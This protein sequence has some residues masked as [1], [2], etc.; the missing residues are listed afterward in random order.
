MPEFPEVTVVA[1][2]L[3]SLVK[4]KKIISITTITP[5]L[6]K[7]NGF[8][9]FQK[10][11]TDQKIEKVYNIGKFI[12]FEL[13]NDLKMISHLRMEGK[14]FF[15]KESEDNLRNKKHDL[16]WFYFSDD[17]VLIYNDTRRFGTLE[18]VKGDVKNAKAIAKLAN[19]PD[20][21]DAK[22]IMEKTKNTKTAIKQTILNQEIVLGIGNI[23]A[24]ESLFAAR[25]SP[26]RP[27]NE[28]TI[29]DWEKL[30]T[31]AQ[32]IMDDS[33]RLG[34]SSVHSYTSVN[35]SKGS[36]QEKLKVYGK[37]GVECPEC[38]QPLT[39]IKVNGRGTTY[40]ERCQSE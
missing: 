5:K 13:S 3:N 23:Y 38:S 21:S 14:Y 4:D 9:A 27:T 16:V 28:L 6:F 12:I 36:Y 29:Q 1:R 32:R 2:T 39:K 20:P 35:A 11:L 8:D 40:C 33:L 24:D 19:L 37:K 30:L 31:S 7:V 26:L 22:V 15:E 34:G 25:I 17:S 10:E 18:F